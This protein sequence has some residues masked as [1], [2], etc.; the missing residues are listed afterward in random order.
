MSNQNYQ[1]SINNKTLKELQTD[2]N[3]IFENMKAIGNRIIGRCEKIEDSECVPMGVKSH[4][5]DSYDK[6]GVNYFR[7]TKKA[8][9]NM[10]EWMR[11]INPNIDESDLQAIINNRL[12]S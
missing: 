10:A 5:P 3:I 11:D 6:D 7:N 12:V 2:T 8:K 9:T 1:Q 4:F